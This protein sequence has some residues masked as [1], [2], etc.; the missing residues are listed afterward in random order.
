MLGSSHDV[1]ARKLDEAWELVDEH[2]RLIKHIV[3]SR[4]DRRSIHAAILARPAPP[5]RTDSVSIIGEVVLRGPF[6]GQHPAAM[7]ERWLCDD[8]CWLT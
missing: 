3:E 6:A 8:S 7:H 1:I 4:L 2:D 5:H